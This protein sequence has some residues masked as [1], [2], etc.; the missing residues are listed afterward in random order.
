MHVS[1]N[2]TFLLISFLICVS[3]IDY[4]NNKLYEVDD[5]YS[6]QFSTKR[7]TG[8]FY[9]LTG[10][11][12]FSLDDLQNSSFDVR[13]DASTIKTGNKTKDKHARNKK[14]LNIKNYPSISFQSENIIQDNEQFLT[15]GTFTI[16]DITRT[17]EIV[18][19][20]ISRDNVLYLSGT[21]TISREAYGIDG[22]SFGFLVGDVIKVEIIAP[23]SYDK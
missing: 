12:Q 4:S 13:V 1:S 17:Q 9:N 14:W 2:I 8:S 15:T 20:T 5:N 10:T 16:K 22:N 23:A 11:I 18:F 7:A 21:T 6:I 19:D 3:G